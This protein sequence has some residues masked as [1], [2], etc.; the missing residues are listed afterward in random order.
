MSKPKRERRKAAS[1]RDPITGPINA[2]EADLE[3]GERT[4]QRSE[5]RE[6]FLTR[7]EKRR[8]L[9]AESEDDDGFAIAFCIVGSI[10]I[11]T[12]IVVLSSLPR[13]RPHSQISTLQN[14]DGPWHP[15][16][17]D[18]TVLVRSKLLDE[19]P[20]MLPP[21][22]PL[23]TQPSVNAVPP[24]TIFRSFPDALAAPLAETSTAGYN[25]GSVGNPNEASHT[26]SV[27]ASAV[28]TASAAVI[29]FYYVWY[30]SPKVTRTSTSAC[31]CPYL[32]PYP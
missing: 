22:P 10:C 31:T 18:D 7:R 19:P 9:A 16:S 14:Y 17:Y 20:A 5:M 3:S 8:Q 30:G 23:P 21:P 12:I 29:A 1:M 26:P 24:Q 32:Y 28:Q 6:E 15:N 25:P 11:V 13:V 27:G 2:L 4:G